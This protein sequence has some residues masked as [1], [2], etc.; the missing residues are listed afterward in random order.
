MKQLEG[1]TALITGCNRGIGSSILLEFAKEG[2]SV[3]ACTRTLNDD[4]KDT[5][6]QLV[7]QF[8]IKIYPICMDLSDAESIKQGMKEVTELRIPIDIL[9][10]NAGVAKFSSLMMS[11]IDDFK[12]LMQVNLYA[13]VQISQYVI[14][15]ML[16]QKK[17]SI[18]NFCSISGLDMNAGNSA[19]GASKAAIASLTR[20]MAKE[21]AK[22]GI[23]VN[24]IAPGFVE[25]DMN[26]QISAD[27]LESMLQQ[28][29]LGRTAKPEEVARTA[30]F[31]AS[32][33]SSYMTGQ[34]IRIDGGM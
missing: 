6:Q 21:L 24:A 1:K 12:E 15:S 27:Y 4:L 32:D 14:K 7:S 33:E 25:T 3:I 16:K 30:V 22:A 20:T 10:N 29:A 8:N 31:L 18:I 11:K 5:Y 17:G 28:I 23:R 13:P 26:K 34:I 19:Y 2:A 9:V